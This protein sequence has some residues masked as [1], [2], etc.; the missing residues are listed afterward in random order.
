M[1]PD[2][3][4]AGNTRSGVS[5]SPSRVAKEI[6]RASNVDDRDTHINCCEYEKKRMAWSI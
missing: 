6:G 1:T 2:Q 5:F 4:R 3:D